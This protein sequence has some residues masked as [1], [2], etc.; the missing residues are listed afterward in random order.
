MGYDE[1]PDPVEP[2]DREHQR[3]LS[4]LS[5]RVP[6]I[7]EA[8]HGL[9]AEAADRARE[10]AD[11]LDPTVRAHLLASL[12]ALPSIEAVEQQMTDLV[13]SDPDHLARL[14]CG[15]GILT[16]TQADPVLWVDDDRIQR[17]ADALADLA[18]RAIDER[19]QGPD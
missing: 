4:L 9:H 3:W 13:A 11:R 16:A 5:E 17:D 14:A 10:I 19:D 2:S 1:P 8:L 15:L 6:E 12:P 18:D 7:A